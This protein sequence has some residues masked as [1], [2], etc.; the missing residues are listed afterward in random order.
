MVGR[1][2]TRWRRMSVLSAAAVTALSLGAVNADEP[3]WEAQ[4]ARL[5]VRSTTF[6]QNGPLPDSVIYNAISNGVNICTA[7]GA[8]GADQSPQLH[9]SQV[10]DNTR[11]FVVVL[12]DTTA[13]F[14]HWGMYNI[15]AHVRTLPANA[16]AA[17]STFGSQVNND[18]GDPSYDGPCPPAGVAPDAHHYVFTVYALDT[19]LTLS[20]LANFPANAETL[21][22]ALLHAA[23]DG[24][25]L[26]SGSIATYYSATPSG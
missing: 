22:H 24:H 8:V 12:Y 7:N 20:S 9:W 26:A 18:F 15:A 21:Y 3:L 5:E 23:R 14:T 10:P 4:G 2:S 16:G 11:S 1:K 25:I 17:A 6:A 19:E 13:A